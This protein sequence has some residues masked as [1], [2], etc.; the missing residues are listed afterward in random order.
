MEK[1]RYL[2][3]HWMNGLH[4]PFRTK[5]AAAEPRQVAAQLANR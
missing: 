4:W 1:R 5:Q 2:P 3:L